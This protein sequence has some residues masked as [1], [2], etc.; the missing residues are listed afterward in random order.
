MLRTAARVRPAA[1]GLRCLST[2][3]VTRIAVD[4]SYPSSTRPTPHEIFH[5]PRTASQ[6]EIKDRY[7]E[8]VRLHHPD[9]PACRHEPDQL[10]QERFKSITKAY[11]VLKN[12]RNPALLEELHRRHTHRG[13]AYH[14]PTRRQQYSYHS[15]HERSMDVGN[16]DVFI[17]VTI[18]AIIGSV[19]LMYSPISAKQR[20]DRH[21]LTASQALSEA[22]KEGHQHRM[23]RKE[24]IR[25]WVED[26]G[27][28]GVSTDVGHGAQPRFPPPA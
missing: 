21:H 14:Y 24:Q 15:R 23:Y 18:L 6:E 8:L 28:D 13:F 7:Y 25:K 26:S 16:G 10:R 17:V 9:S 11:D 12:N 27:L 1:H 2:S 22:R 5:L 19:C 4:L 20:G 3:P